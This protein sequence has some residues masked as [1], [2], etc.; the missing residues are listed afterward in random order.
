[1]AVLKVIEILSSSEK[2][3]EDATKQAVEK[4]SKTLNNIRSV[5]VKEQSAAVKN[6]QVTEF[7]VNLKVTF[8]LD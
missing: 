5:Y 2:S 3:W 1:M 6:N 4:A 8:E 7:R